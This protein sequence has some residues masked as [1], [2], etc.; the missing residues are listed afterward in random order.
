VIAYLR[1]KFGEGQEN[2]KQALVL[3]SDCEFL[4]LMRREFVGLLTGE[5][6]GDDVSPE[7]MI[8]AF[9][10]YQAFRVDRLN[11]KLNVEGQ[12]TADMAVQGLDVIFKSHGEA[13]LR[14]STQQDLGRSPVESLI[15]ARAAARNAKD[16]AEA[17]RIRAELDAMGIQLKD[18]K[19]P[20]S[21]ELVTTWEV[22][23]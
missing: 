7:N 22:K 23:R 4:G 6:G 9:D 20:E 13:H 14:N 18:S 17:D 1:R 16:F 11:G 8:K 10:A 3:L 2:D 5:F 15:A 12:F 21:G 19:D